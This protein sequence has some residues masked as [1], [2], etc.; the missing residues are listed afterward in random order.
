MDL[1]QEIL[2]WIQVVLSVLIIGA[3][4]FQQSEAGLGSTFGSSSF[5]GKFHTKRGL[6]KQ[7]FIATIVL[8]VLFVFAALARLFV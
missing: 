5:S 8:V 2:P 3:I 7:I 6:E 1:L 4:L